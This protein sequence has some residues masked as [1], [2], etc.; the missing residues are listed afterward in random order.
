MQRPLTLL[1]CRLLFV[2]QTILTQLE[3]VKAAGRGEKEASCIVAFLQQVLGVVLR[4]GV[5]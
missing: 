4:P 3:E 2:P 1:P 5:E